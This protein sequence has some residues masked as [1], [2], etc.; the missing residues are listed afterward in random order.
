MPELTPR[1]DSLVLYK[2]RPARVERAGK[3]L[4]IEL[5]GGETLKV[6]PKDVVLLHPGSIQSLGELLP[7]AGELEIAWELLA[8]GTTNLAELAE[9]AY[10]VYTPATA[11]AAWQSVA[12]G[13]YFSG[14]PEEVVVRSPDEVAREQATRKAQVAEERARA[15]FLERVRANEL[16]PED[17]LYLR[18]VEQLAWGQRARSLVLRDLGRAESPENAHALL[19]ELGHWDHTANPYPQ[20][21]GLVTSPVAEGLPE[22]PEEDRV[23]L[24]HLPAFAI[25]D[26]GNQEPDDALSLEGD[27]LWI[28]VA[29]AAALVQ[30]NSAA[31]L[32]ARARGASLYLPEGT[33][34]MLPLHAIQ[35]LGLGLVDVSPS[36][37]VGL[38]LDAEMEIRGVEVVRSWVRVTRLTYKEAEDRLGE[39]PFRGLHCLA[40]AHRHR[41]QERGA[42]S[43]ELPEVRMWVE[44]GRVIIHPL[45][46]LKSRDLV[47]E[48]ML[49]A[50]EAVARYAEEREIPIP[51][52]TQAPP[53]THER[54]EDL[55]GMYALRRAFRPSQPSSAPGPHAGLGLEIYAQATSPLRRYLD[56]VVHQQIRAHLRGE[57]L[58]EVQEVLER[59][60]ATVAVIGSVRRAERLVRRHWTL[61][62]LLEHPGWRGEG[63]L[64]DKRGLRGTVLI[65]C[66]DLDARVHLR[67]DLPLN[68]QIHLALGEVNLAE[69]IAHFQV[70]G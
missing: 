40:Q 11:W 31:D 9:L 54:P 60:G 63:I 64:M 68:S 45:P 30:P 55:A 10:G 42:I 20:R 35:A 17:G 41:R 57:D 53:K 52:T 44:D 3:K 26:E 66:L 56:L 47:T 58:L 23:D 29:D 16:G 1:Q 33:V 37:S 36:L 49:M 50:G 61:V 46:P 13:L 25:D 27:R 67:Q 18:E 24:T 15:A 2:T 62:Y 4:E 43:I 28:H 5:E 34:P 21:L 51:F 48:A 69:Q 8:G 59:V 14:T 32:E 39:E 65:P 6:R 19:L 12:D 38:D 7:Q 70:V 22:L